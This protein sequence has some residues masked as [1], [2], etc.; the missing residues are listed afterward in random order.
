MDTSNNPL[1]RD[2]ERRLSQ[3]SPFEIKNELISLA[4][5]DAR[6]SSATYLNAGR[7][8]P[9]WIC[10]DAREAFLLIGRF[11]LDESRRVSYE[12]PGIAGCPTKAGIGGRF[13]DFLAQNN[14]TEGGILLNKAYRYMVDELKADPDELALEWADG[15]IGDIIRHLPVSLSIRKKRS[16]HTWHRKWGTEHPAEARSMISLQ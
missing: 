12:A 3:M 8:N 10:S 11:A 16:V 14:T 13:E 5:E 15:F 9:N 6:K 1:S 2:Y 7:G 4:Q